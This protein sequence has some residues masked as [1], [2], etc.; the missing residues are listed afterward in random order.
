M[1]GKPQCRHCVWAVPLSQECLSAGRVQHGAGTT[2]RDAAGG[3]EAFWVW[4]LLPGRGKQGPQTWL[5]VLAFALQTDPAELG[6]LRK[7]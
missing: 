7:L 4:A 2:Q 3:E 6:S 5:C 1:L